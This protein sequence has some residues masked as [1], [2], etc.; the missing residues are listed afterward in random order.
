MEKGSHLDP[1]ILSPTTPVPE[2][3]ASKPMLIPLMPL[4]PTPGPI[5]LIP[6][7]PKQLPVAPTSMPSVLLPKPDASVLL[8]ISNFHSAVSKPLSQHAIHPFIFVICRVTKVGDQQ[9]RDFCPFYWEFYSSCLLTRYVQSTTHLV[10][11]TVNLA[12][13]IFSHQINLPFFT[14]QIILL[15]YMSLPS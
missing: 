4:A 13:H 3:S 1:L 12:A 8:P 15:L 7:T 2:P 6:M 14:H 9:S 10:Y 5:T 11:L